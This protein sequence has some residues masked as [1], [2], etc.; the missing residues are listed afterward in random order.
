MKKFTLIE[1]LVVI[2]IIAILAGMLLPALSKARDT[3]KTSNCNSNLKQINM[4]SIMYSND[5]YDYFVPLKWP[6]AGADTTQTWGWILYNGKYLNN[7]LCRCPSTPPDWQYSTSC[8][9]PVY[10]GNSW[11][12]AWTTYSYNAALGSNYIKNSGI[13]DMPLIRRGQCFK[14]STVVA[15]SEAIDLG[16]IAGTYSFDGNINSRRI[17]N[18]HS[19][20]ANLAWADGHVT[21][22]KDPAPIIQ[23]TYDAT[24]DG[25]KYLNPFYKN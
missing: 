12:F 15:F 17:Y 11:V 1:L 3:A 19:G 13:V 16:A 22:L 23:K 18:H 8:L 4:S 21:W 14:P 9:G 7:K 6:L 5:F 24:W 10:S 25:F 2:A 20:G